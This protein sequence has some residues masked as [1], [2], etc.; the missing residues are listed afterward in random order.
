MEN[1]SE[2][3]RTPLTGSSEAAVPESRIGTGVL[4]V[5]H[6]TRSVAGQQ[7]FLATVRLTAESL[8][9]IPVEAAYL[10]LVE[11]D[12]ATGLACLAARGISECIIAPLLLFA[13]GHAK[14]DIPASVSAAAE[15]FPG[16]RFRQAAHLGLHEELIALSARRFRQSK[17]VVPVA[18]QVGRSQPDVVPAPPIEFASQATGRTLAILVGRG[19]LDDEALDEMRQFTAR[20]MLETPVADSKTCFLAMAKPS[21]AETLQEAGRLGFDDVVVQPHLLFAGELLVRARG[22]VERAASEFPSVRWWLAE[23][24]GPDIAVARALAGRVLAG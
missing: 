17:A 19:S 3:V 20:R 14:H 15:R 7:E 22:E 1:R 23:H 6:G 8:S 10:E 21:L 13:A 18:A 5:G 11:P 12:I 4:I 24:L 2:I 16:I 9:P